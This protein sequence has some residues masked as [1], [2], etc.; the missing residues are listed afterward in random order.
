MA[1]NRDDRLATSDI[2]LQEPI[3][4]FLALHIT[5]DFAKR[6]LLCISQRKWKDSPDNLTDSVID[7][8]QLT[9]WFPLP[10]AAAK[11][12]GER[13]PEELLEDEAPVGR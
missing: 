10:L 13:Q 5:N 12:K 4:R 8:D 11:P 7:F 9:L 2:T 3:H 6:S 1:L